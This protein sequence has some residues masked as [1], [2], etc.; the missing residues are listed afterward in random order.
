[1]AL[2]IEHITPQAPGFGKLNEEAA[3][4]GYQF[5]GR[6]E[7]EWRDGSNRFDLPGEVLFGAFEGERLLGVCGLNRD[8]YT[9]DQRIGRLRHLYVLESERRRGTARTLVEALLTLCASRFEIVR[10]RTDS[11][12][13]AIFY[14]VIGFRLV[15]EPTATHSLSLT[16]P[17]HPS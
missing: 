10:L 11:A 15:N 12:A 5:L 13:A 14:E 9:R 3:A 7:E 17:R 4:S 6:L 1:M 8:P 2:R 16:R